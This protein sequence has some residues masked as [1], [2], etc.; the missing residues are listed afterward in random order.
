MR[1]QM[2]KLV[3]SHIL[4]FSLFNSSH[5]LIVKG[6]RVMRDALCAASWQNSWYLIFSYLIVKA[7]IFS[8]SHCSTALIVSLLKGCAL[9]VTRYALPDG[10][11]RG[12]SYSGYALCVTRYALSDGKTRG[13]SYSHILIVQ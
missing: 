2:A 6:L 12:I 11:T 4:I 5:R 8:Y 1:C 7:L 9:C 10:K 3:V 13:I